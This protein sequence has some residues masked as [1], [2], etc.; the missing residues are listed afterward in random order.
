MM[1]MSKYN[2]KILAL[3]AK[4]MGTK[5]D[6]VKQAI[7]RKKKKLLRD[8]KLSVPTEILFYLMALE[9][10][11]DIE[12]YIDKDILLN[13]TDWQL[14]IE[15]KE[16]SLLPNINDKRD[17]TLIK[18]KKRIKEIKQTDIK[19]ETDILIIEKEEIDISYISKSIINEIIT[20]KDVYPWVYLF[21]NSVRNL[22]LNVMKKNSVSDWW[23]NNVPQPIKRKVEDRKKNEVNNQWHRG[24]RGTHNIYYTDLNDLYRII[25]NGNNWDYF[26]DI[27]PKQS[28]IE[29]I[30]DFIEQSRNIIAHNNPLP[31]DEREDLIKD[32]KRWF[33]Q[34]ED[35]I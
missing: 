30:F 3:L 24:K 2:V 27:F 26:K 11:I 12:S 18:S 22:I 31:K 10:E 17:K 35:K 15:R 21:E 6:S 5:E 32:I 9:N 23:N 25:T 20:M 14:K 29:T 19:I 28:F 16:P 33:R 4:K 7:L 34:I 1:K 13:I 8:Y